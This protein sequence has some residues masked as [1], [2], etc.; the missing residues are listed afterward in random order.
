MSLNK[1]KDTIG[2]MFDDISSQYDFLNHFLSLG[3]DIIWR[4]KLVNLLSKNHPSAILDVA[5]GTGDLAIELSR[6]N[7]KKIVGIDISK[8]MLEIAEE[9]VKKKHLDQIISFRLSDAEKIPFSNNSFDAVTVA[10]GVRNYENLK[11]GIT[12]MRRVLKP[13]GQMLILEF[14]HPS[15]IPVKQFYQLYSRFFIP[16]FGRIISK[17][18]SAYRYLPESVA[19]FPSGERFLDV[20]QEAGMVNRADIKLSFGIATLYSCEK[21]L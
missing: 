20:L 17:N 15:V 8:K 6:L 5:T 13:G 4:K 18:S 10:F 9:K 12:E 7:P 21:S 11:N 2:K 16:F 14:S 3:I 1:K 19:A